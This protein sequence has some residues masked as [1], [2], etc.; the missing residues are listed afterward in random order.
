MSLTINLIPELETQVRQD[1]KRAGLAPDAY[2]NKLLSRYLQR[3]RFFV[4]HEEATLF[5]QIN[6]GLPENSWQRLEYLRRKLQDDNL[7]VEEQQ[8]LINISDTVEEANVTRLE[9]LIQLAL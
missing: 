8:E 3:Q 7:T 4:S 6:A 5:Q 1:A 9:A 2:V